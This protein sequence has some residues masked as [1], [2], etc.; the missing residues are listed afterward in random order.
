MKYT[1]RKIIFI[2]DSERPL[3]SVRDPTLTQETLK[4]TSVKQPTWWR[5]SSRRL[6]PE[7]RRGVSL[8]Y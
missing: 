3:S 1:S 8:K 7:N 5:S 6:R 4:R 2:V